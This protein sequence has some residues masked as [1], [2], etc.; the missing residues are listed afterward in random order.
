MK[1][2][3]VGFMLFCLI[4]INI[5]PVFADSC[6]CSCP[7]KVLCQEHL[8]VC[9]NAPANTV[10]ITNYRK[11][12]CANNVLEVIFDCRFYSKKSCAGDVINF[13]IPEALYTKEGTMI[14]PKCTKIVAEITKVQHPK[15][16]NKNARVRLAFKCVVLPD[17]RVMPICAQPFTKDGTLKEGPWMTTGKIVLCTLT[18]GI[19][20]TGAGVG[21]G[22]I[23]SPT[24]IGV[25][26]AAGIPAGCGVGLLTAL[27][28]KGLQYKAKAGEHVFIILTNDASIYN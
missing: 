16:F 28:S 15:W 7:E 13:T 4:S 1:K 11:I 25:G 18:F 9:K 10:T 23:P 22:F 24:K 14:L 19:I 21:F 17:G 3:L 27:I 6:S 5:S 8:D 20:G 2:F 12:I 26:L